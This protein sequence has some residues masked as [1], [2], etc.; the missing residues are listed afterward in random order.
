MSF[1]SGFDFYF[2]DNSTSFLVNS[3]IS[4][5]LLS[6]YSDSFDV[7][8]FILEN[9][10][11]IS[12][13]YNSGWKSSFYYLPSFLPQNK[14]VLLKAMKES[15]DSKLCIRLRKSGEQKYEELCKNISI[16]SNNSENEYFQNSS[17][18][19]KISLNGSKFIKISSKEE[20]LRNFIIYFSIF[21]FICS[22][23]FILIKRL[24][25]KNK[26]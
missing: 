6:N 5:A 8:A 3:N 24:F 25:T 21:L 2:Q 7:K 11:I 4:I 19:S 16:Y 10:T 14:M 13:T 20:K 12:Q 15:S 17:Q 1:S 9:E 18:N 22:A 26:P 23:I